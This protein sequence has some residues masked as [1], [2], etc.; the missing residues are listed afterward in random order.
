MDLLSGSIHKPA[1]SFRAGRA[2]RLGVDH[3]PLRRNAPM[4]TAISILLSATA[5][6]LGA[7]TAHADP[8]PHFEYRD[9]P[10][11]PSWADPAEWRCE[12]HIATGTLTV[13]GVGPIR[14]RIISM[15]HAEG[16]RPDGTSG[17]VFGRLQAAAERVPGTRLWLRPESA[18]PSDFLTPGGVINLRFRLTGPGLGRHCTLGSAGDPIPI[19]LTPAPGGP[20]QVSANPP[21]RRMQGT[22]TTF[23]VPAATGCGPATRRIDRRFGLPA[24]SGAN[25]LAMTVT[26]SYKTYD[27]LPG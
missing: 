1:P 4:R 7:A 26:Y 23:A 20:V 12:D 18:G 10:P 24:A 9:C 8:P 21:I 22:D 16:P 5:L 13:G 2:K 25:R 19:R 3:Q 11:I 15:T 27:R 17:Q 14:V 6:P